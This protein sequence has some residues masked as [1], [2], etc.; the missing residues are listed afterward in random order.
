MIM[1]MLV[2]FVN[3][4]LTFYLYEV[5]SKEEKKTNK[6]GLQ[7]DKLTLLMILLY[8]LF[9]AMIAVGQ[10]NGKL[11]IQLNLQ[12][13]LDVGKVA[14]YM[15]VI[16]FIS[17]IVRLFSNLIFVKV[18]DKLKNKIAYLFETVLC[19]S[20]VLLIVGNFVGKNI[21]GIIV[22]VVGYCI[23]L[24]LRDPFST[25]LKKEIFE[26]S[27]ESIHDKIVNG[28]LLGVKIF[29]L[30]YGIVISSM[31]TKLSY[32]YVMIFLLV[33]SLIFVGLIIKIIMMLD[34][35]KSNT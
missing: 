6:I 10:K 21:Y 12:D 3:F 26:H 8:G 31:L 23:Y 4:L 30:L 32:V 11:F 29:T 25:W 19:L 24:F 33:V 7:I 28:L 16:I 18:Y 9:Y 5:P 22:M 35:S 34:K 27:D 15:S 13:F 20:F 2:S 14:I 1:C 17:R